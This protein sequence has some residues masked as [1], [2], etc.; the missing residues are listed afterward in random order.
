MVKKLL[1][2]AFAASAAFSSAFA[3]KAEDCTIYLSGSPIF[4]GDPIEPNIKRVVC[5]DDEITKYGSVTYGE[6]INAGD[7]AGTVSIKLSD[8]TKVEKTFAI[9]KKDVKII[10][11]D[12]E[13]EK[14]TDDPDFTWE[15]DSYDK[16]KE[17]LNADTLANFEEELKKTIKLERTN[18]SEDIVDDDG[19]PYKYEI[20]LLA[21]AEN[22]KNSVVQKLETNFPNY[23]F[24]VKS[25]FLTI[26]KTKVTVVAKSTSKVYGEDDPAFEYTINGNIEKKDY[27]K[28]GK[29]AVDRVAGEDVGKYDITV[30]VE[31][32]DTDDYEVEVVSGVLG[33]TPAP[34]S[35]VVDDVSKIYGDATPKFTYKVEGLV[36]TDVLTGV[37]L[38]C[39]KCSKTGLESVGEYIISVSVAETSNKNYTLELTNGT[40]SVTPRKVTVTLDAAEKTYGDK[41]PKYTFTSKGVVEGETLKGEIVTREEG[42]DVGSYKVELSFD[43]DANPNYVITPKAGTLKINPKAVTLTAD[44]IT[45]K[46]GEKDPELTYTVDALVGQDELEGVV[47]S[48][49]KGEN[50]G[51]YAITAKVD[52]KSNPNYVVTVEGGVFTISANDDK[53]VVTI[54]GHVDTVGYNGKEHVVKGFEIASNS[55]AFSVDFVEYTGDSSVAGKDAGTYEMGLAEKDFKNTSVNYPN[56]TFKVSDGSLVILPKSLV[57]TAKSDSITYGD[58]IPAEFVWTV[59]SLIKGDELDNI[60]VSLKETGLLAAGEYKLVFDKKSPTNKNYVVSEYVEGSLKVMQKVVTVTIADTSKVYGSPDPANYRITTTGLLDGDELPE[61]V[62]AREPGENVLVSTDPLNEASYRISATL[63]PDAVANPNY[64]I[65]VIQGHFTIT[66]YKEPIKVIIIGNTIT[67][68]YTGDTITVPKSFDVILFNDT[69]VENPLPAEYTYLAEYVAY[70]GKPTVSG[71][72][73]YLYPMNF[74]AE[75][76]VN[77]SPNFENVSFALSI[78]GT[79]IINETGPTSIAALKNIKS[80]G[81]ASK[82]RSIQISGSKVGDKFAVLDLRGKTIRKGVVSAA[83]FEIP[84]PTAGVYMVRVGS[85][86]KRIRVK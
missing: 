65:N 42:E 22:P 79:L 7:D 30:S 2:F 10:I 76:F 48:R 11:H 17:K 40:L 32:K 21:D 37:E 28:L 58:E 12:V 49:E 18:K 67:E 9:Y 23:N 43:E 4:T 69:D 60:H 77:I 83:N 81:V 50:S 84:V 33:I 13:K 82:G 61:L 75:E 51:E 52:A 16:L 36:G 57:V 63:A 78:D 6:N 56:V 62:I 3:Y 14:G 19:V 34:A 24:G 73:K 47:L 64:S 20:T 66:P 86:A 29:I 25:G 5:G 80:F 68:K 39:A 31:K 38:S 27:T 35:V 46:F 70:T 45:K 8:G 72:A 41:D 53:I 26:T 74:K 59:D 85:T 15:I 1:L 71:V 44:N 54:T 55:E